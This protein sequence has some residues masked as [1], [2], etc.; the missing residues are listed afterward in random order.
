LHHRLRYRLF[1]ERQVWDVPTYNALEYDKFD[2]SAAKYLL[3]L[4]DSDAARESRAFAL[5]PAPILSRP[6]GLSWSMANCQ[7][8]HRFGKRH[9][10]AA[11]MV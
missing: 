5:R 10:L 9:A 8:V 6:R 3:W 1:I 4:D 2:T 7:A 11:T